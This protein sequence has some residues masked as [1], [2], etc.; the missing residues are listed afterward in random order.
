SI[1]ARLVSRAGRT[2]GRNQVFH[3]VAYGGVPLPA[4]LL[5][6]VFAALLT[7]E[8][9]F[10]L[11]PHPEVETFVA[12]LLR[13]QLIAYSLLWLWSVVIQVMGLSEIQGIGTLKALGMWVLG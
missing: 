8:V 3:V 6:W 7:G 12:L 4:S 10:E 1:Y 13:M 2:V 9:A 11:V 5:L